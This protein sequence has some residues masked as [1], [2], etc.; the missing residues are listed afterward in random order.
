MTMEFERDR[1]DN[2][3]P[4]PMLVIVDPCKRHVAAQPGIDRATSA[5]IVAGCRAALSVARARGMGIAFVRGDAA[6]GPGG[7]AAA[8]WIKG[9][10]P[11]RSDV[12]L[13]RHGPSCYTSEYFDD[14][15]QAAGGDIVI[16]GFAGQGGCIA[17]AA[18]AI[19][20]G[21]R[22]TVLRDATYDKASELFAEPQLHQLAAFTKFGI[23]STT[24]HRWIAS[25]DGS[26]VWSDRCE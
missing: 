3:A 17:T 7:A 16:A 4:L 15:V 22:I 6:A 1:F 24:V 18:D 13:D 25:L 23:R 9:F 19:C 21:H 12:L 2:A 5:G 14:V 26:R 8:G 10:E 20:A 11:S